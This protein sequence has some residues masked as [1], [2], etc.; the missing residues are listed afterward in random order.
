M[1]PP[2]SVLYSATV[3]FS[4]NNHPAVQFWSPELRTGLT[5]SHRL[6]IVSENF[7]LFLGRDSAEVRCLP[8]NAGEAVAAL[9]VVVR[10]VS[11]R[12]SKNTVTQFQRFR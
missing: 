8:V 9:T 6:V 10:R 12:I 7:P 11:G 2:L 5:G 1:A 3:Y 4:I